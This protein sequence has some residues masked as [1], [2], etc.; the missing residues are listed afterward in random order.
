MTPLDLVRAVAVIAVFGGTFAVAKLG[1]DGFPPLFLLFV[2]FAMV[3]AILLPV[4][5]M[6]RAQLRGIF[7]LSLTLGVLH[8]PLLFY[9]VA[10]IDAG[11]AVVASQLQV[12][13]ACLLAALLWNEAF[14]WRRVAGMAL[15]FLGVAIIAGQPR[16]AGRI[17]GLVLVVAASIA[18]A[19]SSLLIKRLGRIDS[20]TLN[21]WL[22][23]FTAPLL[24]ILSLM[25]EQG[26]MTAVTGAG[27]VTW[28]AI[29]YLVGPLTLF[30][31][32]TWYGLL[33]RYPVNCTMPFLLLQPLFG[34]GG[35]VAL[36][37]EPVTVPLVIG[38]ILT[39]A[40]VAVI[41]LRRPRAVTAD[42]A[43][44]PP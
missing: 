28:G 11:T 4:T 44:G 36:L 2:R 3:A 30:A 31:H 29:A 37:G 42:A 14:G 21:A 17:D 32:G 40:G 10:R 22:A 25:L 23:L 19:V 20:F 5:A 38:G 18:Y 13:F 26:Q 34:I 35:A 41:V 8:F 6:P 39:V 12:P 15:A 33:H 16:L 27:W 43:V 1:L 9:G 24:L 7:L